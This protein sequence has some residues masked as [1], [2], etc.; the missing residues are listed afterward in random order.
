MS[1]RS[2]QNGCIQEN[3]TGTS[4]GSGRMS[5]AKK[6]GS[7]Y[8]KESALFPVRAKSHAAGGS[9]DRLI[10]LRFATIQK[11]PIRLAVDTM[12]RED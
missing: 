4:F 8:E 6:R 10:P 2:G 12:G 9:S 5:Q 3:A 1:R 7:E 11:G